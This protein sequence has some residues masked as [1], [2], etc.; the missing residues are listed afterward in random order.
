MRRNKPAGNIFASL[1]LYLCI[2]YI[3]INVR[4]YIYILNIYIY[5]MFDA[6]I[7]TFWVA[8]KC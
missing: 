6:I 3:Y 4:V 5:L 1:D 7:K 2:F 8:N